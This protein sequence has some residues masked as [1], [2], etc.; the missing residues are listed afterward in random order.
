MKAQDGKVLDDAVKYII[1]LSDVNELYNF[2]LSMYDLSLVILIAQH[3]QKDPKEYLPF[4]QSLRD[5]EPEMRKFKIDDQLGNY[6]L[7]VRHLSAAGEDRFD[8]VLNY[9]TLHSLYAEALDMYSGNSAKTK[10]LR[11]LQGVWLVETNKVFE[12]GLAFELA[13]EVKEAVKCYQQAEAWQ[14][15]FALISQNEGDFNI[16]QCAEDMAKRL[17]ASGRYL[18]AGTVLLEY[19]DHL[20]EAITALCDG[21]AFSQAIRVALSKSQPGLVVEVV[22]PAAEEFAESLS[23]EL[24]Q[25]QEQ[26]TKQVD[27]LAE[28][29]LARDT[30]PDLFF[31][32]NMDENNGAL[33]GV[34]AMTDVSTVFHTDYSRY[35]Q[36]FQK[37]HSVATSRAAHSSFRTS[38]L[39]KK[40]A[41]KK[42]AGKKGSIYEEEY[43]L[44]TLAKV[45]TEKL[46]SLQNTLGSLLPAFVQMIKFDLTSKDKL[47]DVS[48]RLQDQL[49]KL[50]HEIFKKVNEVWDEREAQNELNL[51]D[52]EKVVKLQ[53]K[54]QLIVNR[55]NLVNDLM[56]KLSML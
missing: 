34:N 5:L 21:Q 22:M 24:V 28:L 15:M 23:E 11:K 53:N 46:P 37:S 48:K 13:D 44:S 7:A 47:I 20:H 32:N 43:L 33:D 38:S 35:T 12:G 41:K 56:W 8:A 55:P 3:S 54:D 30:N 27:R 14:E 19:G 49:E 51:E 39:R 31:L 10:A 45:C 16:A 9:T 18:E 40:E 26:L 2:A 1:F 6:S 29:K 4:L 36:G 50:Q 52:Q 17:S 42:A 25:L